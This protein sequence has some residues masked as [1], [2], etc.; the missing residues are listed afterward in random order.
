MPPASL[1]LKVSPGLGVPALLS[2]QYMTVPS[3]EVN[4]CEFTPSPFMTPGGYSTLVATV[5]ESGT[6]FWALAAEGATPPTYASACDSTSTTLIASAFALRA[7]S[8]RL[9]GFP[10]MG[11]LAPMPFRT[12]MSVSL[13]P[14]HDSRGTRVPTDSSIRPASDKSLPSAPE[15]TNSTGRVKRHAKGPS[16]RSRRAADLAKRTAVLVENC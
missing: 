3:D 14:V 6:T 8:P 13:L 11:P 5:M 9:P 10:R 2:A 16:R 1:P 7:T 12:P 15:G 4:M